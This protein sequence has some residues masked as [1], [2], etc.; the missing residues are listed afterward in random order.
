[1]DQLELFDTREADHFETPS[2]EW[3][4]G[5]PAAPKAAD[6]MV[7]EDLA[8]D[9]P[10]EIPDWETDDEI[11]MLFLM[12]Q[13]VTPPGPQPGKFVQDAA[14]F[15]VGGLALACVLALIVI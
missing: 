15:A 13:R 2:P 6:D 9:L 3:P 12:C 7:Q 14:T 8:A 1:M 4:F 5:K 10:I 11:E